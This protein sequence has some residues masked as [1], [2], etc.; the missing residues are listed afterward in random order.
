MTNRFRLCAGA[1]RGIGLGLSLWLA[2]GLGAS[3]LTGPA[4]AQVIYRV[5]PYYDPYGRAPF[6]PFIPPRP[7][8]P[9]VIADI[10]IEDYG[11]RRVGRPRFTGEAYVV[12]G[13]DRAGVSV[14]A[15]VDAFDG[16]IIA[17][18]RRRAAPDRV[19]PRDPGPERRPDHA[20]PR[21]GEA[22][23]PPAR[24][25]QQPGAPGLR[26]PE[27]PVPGRAAPPATAPDTRGPARQA[28]AP[29]PSTAPAPAPAQPP[30]ASSGAQG[31]PAPAPLDDG[32]ARP[33]TVTPPVPA[34]P[35]L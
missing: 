2:L 24:P 8:S 32:P 33:S 11:F 21:P 3:V 28:P 20:R 26:G 29:A 16:R 19:R 9:G 34:A 27:P 22:D 5:E 25:R 18:E 6:R 35:L 13:V 1:A 14:R 17:L 7:L 15:E 4:S 31:V 10:L 12:E 23:P 30:A